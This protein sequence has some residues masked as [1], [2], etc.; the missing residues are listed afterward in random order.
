MRRALIVFFSSIL[1]SSCGDDGFSPQRAELEIAQA[2]WRAQGLVL[3]TV[4]A[5]ILC[6]C[7]PAMNQ[8]HELTVASDSIIAIR[9]VDVTYPEG[10]SANWFESVD[11]VFERMRSWRGSMRGNRYEAEFD[12]ATGM[13]LAVDLITSEEILDGGARY[14]FRALKPGLF[15]HASASR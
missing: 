3:Y 5:R 4:E 9:P 11:D 8:W 2:R 13:P 6:F 12:E 7:P 15:T 1:L 10:A 14:E